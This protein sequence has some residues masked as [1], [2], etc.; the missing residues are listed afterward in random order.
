VKIKTEDTHFEIKLKTQN[1]INYD[2]EHLKIFVL[3]D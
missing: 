2:P 1:I 3:K